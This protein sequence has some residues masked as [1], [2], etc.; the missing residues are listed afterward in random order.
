MTMNVSK[1]FL[2]TYRQSHPFAAADVFPLLCPVR[3]KDWIEGWEY[4]MIYSQSGLVEEGCIFATPHHSQQ[5]TIWYVH[6][7]LPEQLRLGFIRHSPNQEV[8]R[9]Q[10]RVEAEGEKSSASHITYEY[11]ALQEER[12]NWLEEHLESDFLKSMHYWEKAINHYLK[13]GTKILT[14]SL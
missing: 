4:R 5:E 14:S 8:V 10:I 6:E 12:Q 3:E 1:K 11:T 13:T 2:K 7:Y 9:I